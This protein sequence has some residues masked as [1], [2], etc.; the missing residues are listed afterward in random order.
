MKTNPRPLG[1]SIRTERYRYTEWGQ[2]RFGV[3]LYDYQQD[4]KEITNLARSAAHTA[5]VKEM[6]AIYEQTLKRTR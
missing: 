4:P 2:G 1:R 5:L 3:E 6:K